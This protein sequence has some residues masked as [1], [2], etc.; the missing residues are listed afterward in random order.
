MKD[1]NWDLTD[2]LAQNS[3][4]ALLL[5]VRKDYE[6]TRIG[7]ARIRGRIL[8]ACLFVLSRKYLMFPC[9][10]TFCPWTSGGSALA[11]M[12][13]ILWQPRTRYIGFPALP[14]STPGK[15]S[16][17]ESEQTDPI[18]TCCPAPPT[19]SCSLVPLCALLE[20]ESVNS[21]FCTIQGESGSCPL[22][23]CSKEH[24]W[25]LSGGPPAVPLF[26]LP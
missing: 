23:P 3:A 14:I 22:G 26:R 15:H 9:L 24:V 4:W 16:C 19:E 17:S 1:K 7:I 20:A 18:S 2:F 13:S 25:V 8:H 21:H 10:P 6:V 5:L 11:S 12:A